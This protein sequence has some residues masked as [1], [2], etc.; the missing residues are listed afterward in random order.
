MREFGKCIIHYFSYISQQIPDGNIRIERK[1]ILTS[2]LPN[3]KTSTK[4][5]TKLEITNQEIEAQL[6]C[7][8]HADFANEFI[9]GGVLSGGTVQEEILF[10][11]KPECLVSML[12]CP[13]MNPNEAIIIYGAL[14]YS[15]YIGYGHSFKYNGPHEMDTSVI[16]A[17]V[18]VDATMNSWYQFREDIVKRD[19]S[20]LFVA[21]YNLP[22]EKRK[23]ATGHWGCGAFGGDKQLKAIEQIIAASEADVELCYST[24]KDNNFKTQFE[25]LIQ[26]LQ[27]TNA[28]IGQLYECI[29]TYQSNHSNNTL[30]SYI[31]KQLSPKPEIQ[32]EIPIPNSQLEKIESLKEPHEVSN[33]TEK[34]S[35][36]ERDSETKLETNKPNSIESEKKSQ[37]ELSNQREKESEK[38]SEKERES[39]TTKPNS[40]ESEKKSHE[41]LSNQ[42]EKESEKEK[43][44]ETTKPNSIESEKKPHEELS[45]QTEKESEKERESEITKPNSIESEKKSHEELSNKTEKESEKERDSETKLEPT[46]P[47][48]FESEKKSHEELSN[49]TEKEKDPETTKPN[50]IESEKKP[51]PELFNKTEKDS[52]KERD[53]ETKLETNKPNSIESEKKSQEELFNPTEKERDPERKLEPTKPNSIESEKKSHEVFSTRTDPSAR[54]CE[55]NL[56]PTISFEGEKKPLHS[57]TTEIDPNQSIKERESHPSVTERDPNPKEKENY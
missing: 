36:K 24:F 57:T 7:P 15:K 4:F 22:V 38:E 26:V 29:F 48:S 16:P 1:S 56:E 23:Y 3:Y 28:T 55:S 46:K 40:L 43:D 13:V 51:L 14:Q 52:Q 53:S 18:A 47:N 21:L 44:P 12:I 17:I 31:T 35:E 54:A 10:V 27:N 32:L 9:G 34:E 8:Y 50:S 41:E 30:F 2:E 49:Q 6:K 25:L 33:Q 42:R 5:L 19:I 37:E 20:K 11:I 39:E 45:N